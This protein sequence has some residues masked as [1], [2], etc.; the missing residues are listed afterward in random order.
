GS[1]YVTE[2]DTIGNLT[3]IAELPHM[4]AKAANIGDINDS[5][6]PDLALDAEASVIGNRLPAIAQQHAG[7]INGALEVRQPGSQIVV[8]R[9]G[10]S[11]VVKLLC[12]QSEWWSVVGVTQDSR[13]LARIV[14]DAES[15]AQGG[16]AIAKDIPGKAEAGRSVDT[17]EIDQPL[18]VAIKA[19]YT[20]AIGVGTIS[21]PNELPNDTRRIY[22]LPWLAYLTGKRVKRG[23]FSDTCT[24]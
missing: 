17:L 1:I 2:P 3:E 23:T 6:K 10:K 24:R 13:S 8:G 5:P 22:L 9:G 19:G 12:V 18:G 14:V 15:A 4:P 11:A 16:L 20:D 7:N 21:E